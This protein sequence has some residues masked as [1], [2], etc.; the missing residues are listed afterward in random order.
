MGP[1]RENEEEDG[2]EARPGDSSRVPLLPPLRAEP[3]PGPSFDCPVVA[4]PRLCRP[5]PPLPLLP[6]KRL[7]PLRSEKPL[8]LVG[9]AAPRVRAEPP[10][11][12]EEEEEAV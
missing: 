4:P 7:S 11:E 9:L 12:A 2:G 1:P 3:A 10:G 8:S 6:P 5:S